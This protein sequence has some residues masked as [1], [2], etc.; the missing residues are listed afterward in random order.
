MRK[1]FLTL[2]VTAAVAG[3]APAQAQEWGQVIGTVTGVAIG[4]QIGNLRGQD[5]AAAMILGGIIGN[6]MGRP[7][8]VPQGYPPV[9]VG[10]SPPVYNSGAY[11]TRNMTVPVPIQYQTQPQY[12]VPFCDN[13]YYEGVYNPGAAQAYCRGQLIRIQREMARQQAEAYQRGA[14][15]Y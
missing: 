10:A 15:G 6:E 13:Q 2:A 11:A 3:T 12:E 4:S 1:L 9:V 14:N 5:R 8:P 7:R